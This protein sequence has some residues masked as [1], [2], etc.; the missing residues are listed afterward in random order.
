MRALPRGW[1]VHEGRDPER[2]AQRLKRRFQAVSRRQAQAMRLRRLIRSARLPVLLAAGAF[3]LTWAL[4]SW[5][6]WPPLATLRHLAAFPNCQ[7][8]RTVGLAP[9]LAG[10]P[11]YYR[12]H[13]AD[14]DGRS[15]EPWL[16]GRN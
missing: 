8:A 11:G 3:L 10:Q 2:E 1:L 12:R 6:P 5:S 4:M 15:C 13:D 9:S 7:A 16:P 14:G